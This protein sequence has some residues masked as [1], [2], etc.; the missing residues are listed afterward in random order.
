MWSVP[1]KAA[2]K[3]NKKWKKNVVHFLEFFRKLNNG[4]PNNVLE[5]P[6]G[7]NF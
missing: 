5:I 7:N 3:V 6:H 1:E 4:R 2:C